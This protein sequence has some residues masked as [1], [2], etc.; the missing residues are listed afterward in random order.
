LDTS[1]PDLMMLALG[2]SSFALFLGY[3]ALC[4]DL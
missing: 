3:I 2:A 1:M 4:V